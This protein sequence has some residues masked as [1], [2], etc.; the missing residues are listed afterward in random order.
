MCQTA[1]EISLTGGGLISAT[2]ARP[3]LSLSPAGSC[4]LPPRGQG[5]SPGKQ[6]AWSGTRTPHHAGGLPRTNVW[7]ADGALLL[8]AALQG[9]EELRSQTRTNLLSSF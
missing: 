9:G 8:L 2:I 4:A 5:P 7:G 3:C 6:A 1:R